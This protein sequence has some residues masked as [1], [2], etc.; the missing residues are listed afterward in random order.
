MTNITIILPKERLYVRVQIGT[1]KGRKIINIFLNLEK[2]NKKKCSVRKIITN[3]GKLTSKPKTILSKLELFYSTLYSRNNS[4]LSESSFLNDSAEISKLS[5][6][7]RSACEKKIT[8]NEC[9]SV[10]QS[11]QKN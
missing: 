9:Y 8:Q 6:E 2:S 11:F 5:E 7:L 3:D 4:R 10:L 1:K